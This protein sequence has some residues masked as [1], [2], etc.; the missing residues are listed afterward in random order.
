MLRINGWTTLLACFTLVAATA[1]AAETTADRAAG[2]LPAKQAVAPGCN[3][4]AD[5]AADRICLNGNCVGISTT[6]PSPSTALAQDSEL[7]G[8]MGI[9]TAGPVFENS[10]GGFSFGV[11]LAAGGHG[12][13]FTIGIHL[14]T[15]A[16]WENDDPKVEPGAEL[17]YRFMTRLSSGMIPNFVLALGYSH[18]TQFD[19]GHG[20]V[21]HWSI[22]H[23]RLGGGLMWGSGFGPKFGFEVSYFGGYAFH[24][25]ADENP[26]GEVYEWPYNG[27][28]IHFIMAF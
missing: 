4:D 7:P 19:E 13:Y 6:D 18:L 10:Y 2:T 22:P 9:I 26:W 21:Y 16:R 12:S 5:C 14:R 28:H 25:N 23:A 15:G 24:D 1:A 8:L 27:G 11:S 20:T 3:T 17:G